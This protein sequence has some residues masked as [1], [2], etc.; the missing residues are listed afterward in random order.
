MPLLDTAT[1]QRYNEQF[2]LIRSLPTPIPQSERYRFS[3]EA[4]GAD[5]VIK[6]G[7]RTYKVTGVNEY[8]RDGFRWPELTLFCLN[9][10]EVKYL[11]WEKEDEISV[12]V[13]LEKLTFQQVGLRNQDQLWQISE[14]EEGA[15]RHNGIRYDYHEDSG[16]KFIRDGKGDG[17]DF[18]QYLFAS[19][20]KNNYICIEEWGNDDDG[21]EHNV[22]MSGKLNPKAIEVLSTG[23]GRD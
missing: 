19:G 2:A 16:V 13:S 7:G 4:V 10:G 23:Q 5:G 9:T 18:H 21:Y 8:E 14:D 20:E 12:F 1:A 17:Q 3:I 6:F 11:E 15:L 22:I